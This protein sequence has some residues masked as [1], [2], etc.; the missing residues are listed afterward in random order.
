MIVAAETA[1]VK[2]PVVRSND[3]IALRDRQNGRISNIATKG[4]H[5]VADHA[6]QADAPAVTR[7]SSSA[8]IVIC[9]LAALATLA[10]NI[11]LPSLPQLARDL[12]VSSAA[13]T[14]AIP[15]FLLAFSVTQL[16]VGPLSDRFGRAAPA[17]AGLFVAIVGTIWC[18]YAQDLTGL[19]IGRVI[20]GAGAGAAGVLA[21]AIARDLYEGNKLERAMSYITIATAA[22]PGF[23]PLLGGA[24]DH[25]LGWRWE[26]LSVAAFVVGTM[27]GFTL[28]VGET[29]HTPQR[30]TTPLT[31][32]RTYFVLM[33]DSR[34]YAPAT[35]TA[36]LMA[37]LFAILAATP[38]LFTE[39]FGFSPMQLGVL[40]AG[41]IFVM[42][43]AGIIAP[44]LSERLGNPRAVLIGLVLMVAGG[45]AVLG[46]NILLGKSALMFIITISLVLFG[47][48]LANPL[49]TAAALAPFGDKA[50][51]AAA[52]V[53]FVIGLG[54]AVGV[55]LAAVLSHDPGLGLGYALVLTSALSLLRHCIRPE[56]GKAD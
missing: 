13:A 34:F 10:T 6:V 45:V 40:F 30:T 19:L 36:L 14:S 21:R 32:A 41:V 43:A 27:V 12:H 54:A 33:R 44:R 39:D 42:I 4:Y 51:I 50:G 16:V 23:S 5:P 7:G 11:F 37:G 48:G 55:P 38:R 28:Y 24:L 18:A 35:T 20:Q 47:A 56:P 31:V 29:N 26:F 17:L 53:G 3:D 25:F 52:L 1:A 49:T 2:W 8:I 22:S 46:C 15:V 9:A